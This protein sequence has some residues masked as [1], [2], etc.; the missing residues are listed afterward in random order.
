MQHILE[1]IDYD[2]F[3]G[4]RDDIN[5]KARVDVPDFYGRTEVKVFTDQ[6][7]ALEDYFEWYNMD[8][9][10]RATFVKMDEGCNMCLVAQY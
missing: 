7:T 3:Q 10:K 8:K 6:I 5:K 1:E 4:Q 9:E 2:E